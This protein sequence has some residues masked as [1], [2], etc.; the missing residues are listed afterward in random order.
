MFRKHQVA[1]AAIMPVSK[2]A[3]PAFREN[4]LDKI[5]NDKVSLIARNDSEICSYGQR[6]YE[7]TANT[8][9]NTSTYVKK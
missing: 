6:M 2:V 7:N 9:T 5:S 1:S 4:V 8:A 3:E